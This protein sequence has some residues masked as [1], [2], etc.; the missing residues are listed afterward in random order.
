MKTIIIKT[1]HLLNF[2]GVRDLTIDFGAT[3]T[4]IAGRNGSGKTTVFDAFTWLLFGKDSQDRTEFDLKTLDTDGRIIYQL[5]HEVTATIAVDGE[6]VTLCRRLI[7]KWPKRNG[8]P[9]FT[10]NQ[11][12]RLFNDV[13]CN[14]REFSAKIAEICDEDTFKKITSPTFFVSQKP[15]KQK[16][17]LLRMSGEIN[18]ADIAAGNPE[19]ESLL[20]RLSNKTIDELKREISAKKSR[21]KSEYDG[22]PDRIDERKRDIAEHTDDWTAIENEIAAVTAERDD[23]DGQLTDADT[24]AQ[25]LADEKYKRAAAIS[26]KRVELE[27]RRQTVRAAAMSEYNEQRLAWERIKNDI[28]A[29]KYQSDSLNRQIA[30][31]TAVLHE[32]SAKRQRM[33]AKYAELNERSVAIAAEQITFNDDDFVC[34]M[35]HRPLD[36]AD[37]AERQQSMIDEFEQKRAERAAAVADEIADNVAAG[38]RLKSQRAELTAGIA[39]HQKMLTENDARINELNAEITKYENIAMPDVD[40]QIAADETAREIADEIAHMERSA[41]PD[42]TPANNQRDELKSRRIELNARINELN[43]RLHNRDTCADA[44]QR[45]KDLEKQYRTLQDALTEIEHIEYVIAEF[46]KAKSEAIDARINGMFNV[47]RFRWLKYLINGTEKETCEATIN[48]VPYQSL[49]TA[50]RIAAGIDIINTICRF[51]GITAPIFID[52]RESINAL[53]PVESQIVNLTV[54]TDDEITVTTK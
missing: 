12:E 4:T 38:Q 14:E 35:C 49:N 10:G 21:I 50:G 3:E 5:P 17:D 53:P 8:E 30:N 1:L 9:T 11:V 25:H 2:K 36:V 18:D 47:V 41:E 6:D 48:G 39:E 29:A 52:N 31:D 7:E 27:A 19:F 34:P 51:E 24:A 46:S 45:I 42:V 20:K 28:A 33:L 15:E 16:S 13:P 32:L 54:S 37:I 26:R 40:A 23:V 44:E 22:I 43:K